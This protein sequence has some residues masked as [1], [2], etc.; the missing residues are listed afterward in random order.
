[1]KNSLEQIL[2]STHMA[3]IPQREQAT[4]PEKPPNLYGSAHSV[5]LSFETMLGENETL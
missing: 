3:D 2:E 1:M 5:L 4:K